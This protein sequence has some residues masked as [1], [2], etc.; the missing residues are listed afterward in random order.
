MFNVIGVPKQNWQIT[1][2]YCNGW[3]IMKDPR[4]PMNESQVRSQFRRG[5]I[6][7][8]VVSIQSLL[9]GVP[10]L[11]MFDEEGASCV[12]GVGVDGAATEVG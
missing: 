2:H 12:C 5:R 1:V 7:S 11:A 8:N 10:I 3:E 6:G 4:F 9:L